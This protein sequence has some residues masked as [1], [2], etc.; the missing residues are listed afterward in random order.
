MSGIVNTKSAAEWANRI[1]SSWQKAVDHIFATGD[2]LLGAKAELAHGEF[3]SMINTKL[4]FGRN[5]AER[6]MSVA[7]NEPLRNLESSKGAHAPLLPTSWFTLY[8]LTK[9][10]GDEFDAAL[11][12]GVIRSD[13]SRA[14]VASF[15]RQLRN[16]GNDALS[17]I[18]TRR[19]AGVYETIVIDPPW[20]MQKIERDVRPNQV[21]FD[22]PTM[23]E[24]QLSEFHI[25]SADSCHMFCWTTHKFLPMAFRLL[26]PWGF[27]YV[28][29]FVWH[30]PGGFQPHGLPQFNCEFALYA[31]KGT[32]E[33]L[34]TKDFPCCFEAPRREHSRKPDIFYDR[35]R[36]VTAGP[37]ID[38]FSREPR[39]GFDQFGN[40]A[41]KFESVA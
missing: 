37:R 16:A 24:Q 34:D 23:N 3:I 40:E 29:T 17:L 1:N 32:P 20:P 22:Y 41:A 7:L 13:M 26:D 38:I 27:R 8:E 11:E 5:T 31:R 9:L 25:P 35:V 36:R 30:K 12:A 2:S 10:T 33:L 4:D 18:E 15:R 21:E 28:C 19:M 39:D 14:D 6:L